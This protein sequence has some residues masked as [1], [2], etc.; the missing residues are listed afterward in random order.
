[1]SYQIMLEHTPE[2]LHVT[3][4]GRATFEDISGVWKDIARACKEF[5]CSN[6]LRDG[7]LQGKAS[8]LD[9]YRIG[10][11]LHEFELPSD[12]RVAFVCKKE[13]LARLEFNETVITTRVTGIT[14]RNF[15]DRAEATRWLAEKECTCQALPAPAAMQASPE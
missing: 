15:L 3:V 10:N 4:T 9:V 14:I 13:N 11:R 8:L 7:I 6:V 12:L 5:G 2:Y 1:M